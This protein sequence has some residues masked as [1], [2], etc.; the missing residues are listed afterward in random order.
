MVSKQA[1]LTGWRKRLWSTYM[2]FFVILFIFTAGTI[3]RDVF[4]KYGKKVTSIVYASP[5]T[6][7]KRLKKRTKTLSDIFL[8]SKK[9]AG[10]LAILTKLYQPYKGF[11]AFRK[12]LEE[13]RIS[14][15]GVVTILSALQGSELT[16]KIQPWRKV[17]LQ[18]HTRIQLAQRKLNKLLATVATTKVELARS[19]RTVEK[20]A[21]QTKLLDESIRRNL[22]FLRVVSKSCDK[23]L[24]SAYASATQER[25]SELSKELNLI[26]PFVTKGHKKLTK[27]PFQKFAFPDL[28]GLLD[29]MEKPSWKTFVRKL[30]ELR[31]LQNK[32]KSLSPSSSKPTEAFANSPQGKLLASIQFPLDKELK[33]LAQ[34]SLPTVEKKKLPSVPDYEML[35]FQVQDYFKRRHAS[36]LLAEKQILT[37]QFNQKLQA[38]RSKKLAPTVTWLTS[39]LE[40][41][42]R[43][44]I[45]AAAFNNLYAIDL[46]SGVYHRIGDK[47]A[48]KGLDHMR[49][50]SKDSKLYTVI[51][52]NFYRVDLF[53]NRHRLNSKIDTWRRTSAIAK[54]DD[55]LFMIQWDIMYRV[56]TQGYS[57][58]RMNKTKWYASKWIA[59]YAGL[60]YVTHRKELYRVSPATGLYWKTIKR[61]DEISRARSLV[62]FGGELFMLADGKLWSFTKGEK[63]F[64]PYQVP[65]GFPMDKVLRMLRF[66]KKL[67][68]FT[69]KALY[70][71]VP[72]KNAPSKVELRAAFKQS[73]GLSRAPWAGLHN[74]TPSS[75]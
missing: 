68:L 15:A 70:S 21:Q 27:M 74:A 38:C 54:I 44:H 37:Q 41:K 49:F 34:L 26:Q 45:F 43:N 42:Y 10:S 48:W 40:K 18:A 39:L 61:Q 23:K 71:W 12:N 3:G 11:D 7:L 6:Q 1:A 50:V 56:S 59:P 17:F 31:Q 58:S 14:V 16:E 52:K 60:L 67:Y 46:F 30:S 4:R 13:L 73:I 66:K 28:S 55:A 25:L 53:G 5:D 9:Q 69:E 19:V 62:G 64:V 75:L 72:G 2:V 57:H 63:K 24:F 32:T 22:A 33:I 36:G 35:G 8:G 47:D 51:N 20:L 65:A 29:A